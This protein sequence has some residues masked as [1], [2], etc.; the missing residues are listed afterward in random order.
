MA[1]S[2]SV[3]FS[4]S[5]IKIVKGALRALGV[6]DVEETPSDADIKYGLESLN[7][8][9]KQ[10]MGP[11]GTSTPGLKMWQRER[12][13]LVLTAKNTFQFKSSAGDLD[14]DIPIAIISAVLRNTDD[15][16][17]PLDPMT[18]AEYQAIVGK[19]ETGTPSKYYYERQ[20]DAGYFYLNIIP[21]DI[22]DTIP[23]VFL[24]PLED[25]DSSSNTPDFPQEWYRPL[26][27]LLSMDLYPEY[28]TTE[29]SFK[30]LEKLA[31][32]ALA[33]AQTF[34][35][36]DALVYFQPGKD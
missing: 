32:G 4:A 25:F 33:M 22:T 8:L 18:L 10:L 3:D 23:L 11:N 29:V 30:R 27:F 17:T 2:G 14:I 26:K 19:S 6:I 1:T 21:S 28:E 12:D 24:R 36:D 31:A 5:A 9:V 20:L 13:T 35:P 16:D 7:M 15:Q 34:E